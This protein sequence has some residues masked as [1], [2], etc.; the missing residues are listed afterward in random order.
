M[1]PYTIGCDP[2]FFGMKAGQFV[3]MIPFVDGTKDEPAPLPNGGFVMRDNVAVEFGIP[4]ARTVSQWVENINITLADMKEYLPDD[5]ELVAVPS[6]HFPRKE[7]NHDEAK[8][9]GCD[10]D[11]NA[12]SGEKNKPPEGCST[13]T[14]RSCGGHIHVGYV[15]GSGNDFLLDDYG[16]LRVI[17]TMDCFHGMFSTILDNSPEA[18]ARR[19]LYGKA[20]CFR[21]TDYG[22]EYRTLS[23][24]WCQTDNLKRL[25]YYLTD[26]V[27]TVVRETDDEYV[28]ELCGGPD[29]V[30]D[31]I[32]SG[33]VKRA[34]INVGLL[35]EQI[36]VHSL[37]TLEDCLKE[38][39]DGKYAS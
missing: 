17:R 30:Q 10:P 29:R 35:R 18:I 14:F 36:S 11:F 33:D 1:N 3:A 25:M 7:L 27:L 31:V 24:F 22:V 20:G 2:E 21:P 28:I 32:N 4:P 19:K 5:I 16:K 9:F 23:N 39:K 8:E 6:A 26:D 38:R 37:Q 12:W 13:S 34:K 15:Q